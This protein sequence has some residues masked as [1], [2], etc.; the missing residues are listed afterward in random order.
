MKGLSHRFWTPLFW[1]TRLCACWDRVTQAA[2]SLG[3]SAPYIWGDHLTGLLNFCGLASV[4]FV[5]VF[6]ACDCGNFL[7]SWL[8]WLV[9]ARA[10]IGR[11]LDG[12]GWPHCRVEL[13]WLCVIKTSFRFFESPSVITLQGS[14]HCLSELGRYWVAALY[15]LGLKRR[16]IAGSCLDRGWWLVVLLSIWFIVTLPQMLVNNW[17]ES[18]FLTQ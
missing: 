10:D 2:G 13:D 14:G 7:G 4:M 3:L 5:V 8:S 12:L 17:V 6:I 16:C 9:V 15:F 1:V 11:K 18:S